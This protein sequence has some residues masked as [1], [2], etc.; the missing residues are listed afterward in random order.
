MEYAIGFT[1][2]RHYRGSWT[3][4]AV[5]Q[6]PFPTRPEAEFFRPTARDV[7]PATR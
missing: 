5:W 3:K 1:G 7:P 6:G 2:D 4:A